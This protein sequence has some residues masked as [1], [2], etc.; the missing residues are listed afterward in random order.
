[1]WV[2]VT[3]GRFD[4]GGSGDADLGARA[5]EDDAHLF[6]LVGPLAG[7]LGD[8]AGELLVEGIRD[9]RSLVSAL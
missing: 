6:G 2:D 3:T 7:F 1:M 5:W 8:Q 4:V 9:G